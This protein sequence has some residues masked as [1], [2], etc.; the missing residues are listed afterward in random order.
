MDSL[1]TRKSSAESIFY[2]IFFG[3]ILVVLAY[4]IAKHGRRILSIGFKKID[5]YMMENSISLDKEPFA[6]SLPNTPKL[7]VLNTSLGSAIS[8]KPVDDL[9]VTGYLCMIKNTSNN[10]APIH[11]KTIT[12]IE[13]ATDSNGSIVLDLDELNE[14]DTYSIVVYPVTTDG[15]K[16]LPSNMV[17]AYR[18]D[19]DIETNYLTT[20]PFDDNL[21]NYNFSSNITKLIYRN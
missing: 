8:F 12:D 2:F 18:Q 21:D 6:V 15:E 11:L 14:K 4:Y 3:T 9:T 1:P 10:D 16:G 19:D 13:R 17:Y 5:D 7:Y 20:T